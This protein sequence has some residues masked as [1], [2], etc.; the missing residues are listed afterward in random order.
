MTNPPSITELVQQQFGPSAEQ[1]VTSAFHAHGDDLKR[2]V[3]LAAPQGHERVLD[4]ATGGG[5]TALAFAPLVREVVALDLT[6]P[7]LDAASAF[8]T[9]KGVANVSYRRAPA[10][11]LPFDDA[12]FDIVTC[13]IAAHHFADAAAFARESARV[14]RPGG[15]FL[16]GD[17]LGLDD[18]ELDAFMDRF[19]RW[20][21]PSHVRAYSEAE[22]RAFLEPVGLKVEHVEPITRNSYDF[23][24]WT[25]R[26]RTPA[27]ER[28]ALERWLLAAEPRFKQFFA[29][30][31][32]DGR[33]ESLRGNFGIIVARKATNA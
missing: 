11:E 15:I 12:S 26:I 32:K 21:D 22:W 2:L 14:L 17:H 30:A 20:R 8:I 25:A 5:H 7:M 10:E 33:V 27:H 16:L 31:E 1:Y 18:P 6:Q 9:S 3:E 24:D 4:V 28:E 13:R 29:I 23:K 19:E